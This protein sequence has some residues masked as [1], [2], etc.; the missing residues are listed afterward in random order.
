MQA[1]EIN[2]PFRQL[3]PETNPQNPLLDLNRQL[4]P[5]ANLK[6]NPPNPLLDLNRQLDPATN[7]QNPL[8]DLNL[9]PTTN[10]QNQLYRGSDLNKNR[11]VGQDLAAKG[12]PSFRVLEASE[13]PETAKGAAALIQKYAKSPDS[14]ICW[15]ESSKTLVLCISGKAAYKSLFRWPWF[16]GS[17][18]YKEQYRNSDTVSESL[19]SLIKNLRKDNYHAQLLF[20]LSS[21]EPPSKP[22]FISITDSF[23]YAAASSP[24]LANKYKHYYTIDKTLSRKKGSNLSDNCSKAVAALLSGLNHKKASNAAVIIPWE[25]GS[26]TGFETQVLKN[27]RIPLQNQKGNW[28]FVDGAITIVGDGGTVDPALAELHLRTLTHAGPKALATGV[29]DKAL[30]QEATEH[31]RQQIQNINLNNGP[32]AKKNQ[33]EPAL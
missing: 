23:Y 10:P 6:T 28:S 29:S 4:D 24:E 14:T 5:E 27:Y 12:E 1:A 30:I 11:K 7:P 13:I 8:L 9:D 19:H 33:T 17:K 31:N 3:G 26:V 2:N 21:E 18:L 25:I 16:L 20:D 22:N 15:D 32:S